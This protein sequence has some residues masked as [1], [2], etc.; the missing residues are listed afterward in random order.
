[1]RT[2][3]FFY[4]I[5]SLLVVVSLA[6][7]LWGCQLTPK[8]SEQSQ[9]EKQTQV[10]NQQIVKNEK[11]QIISNQNQG[12]NSWDITES[13][14]PMPV[15]LTTKIEQPNI[16]KNVDQLKWE[17]NKVVIYLDPNCN[18][19]SVCAKNDI[20]QALKFLGITGVQVI[21]KNL[22]KNVDVYV[23]AIVIPSAIVKKIVN[24]PQIAQIINNPHYFRK[25]GDYYITVIGNWE[26]GKENLCNDWKDNDG[27]GKIDVQD[28]DCNQYFAVLYKQK[29]LQVEQLLNAYKSRLYGFV[30]TGIDV[31]SEL[32]KKIV[33]AIIK[34]YKNKSFYQNQNTILQLQDCKYKYAILQK[35]IVKVGKV[36]RPKAYLYVMSHCPFGTQAEKAYLE[37]I[38]AFSGV[39]DVQIKFVPYIMHGYQEAVDNV[40]QY[41]VSKVYP[42]KFI[43]YMKCFLSKEDKWGWDSQKCLEKVGISFD[44]PNF[45]K[46]YD[47]TAKKVDLEG[48]KNSKERFPRFN[49]NTTWA[50]QAGV[51]G[52]PTFVLNGV[53]IEWIQRNA[54]AYAEKICES[55]KNPPEICKHLDKFS[56]TVYDPGLWWTSGGK[57]VGNASCWGN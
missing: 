33:D 53:K 50:Y 39:A 38:K 36:D 35:P 17:P 49:L 6:L 8:N 29:N 56:D 37:I 25:V 43:D 47:E 24:N 44:D 7:F 5:Y 22:P 3:R 26:N 55:F 48:I 28:P 18:W 20:E 9:Q 19:Q 46:C 1:M 16:L 2:K 34:A 31:N 27:D 12:T 57:N 21:Y 23:P 45:K 13:D 10:K 14:I 54:R 4:T 52:S 42:N 11:N 15:L 40:I 51:Q 32:W 30:I 41:C